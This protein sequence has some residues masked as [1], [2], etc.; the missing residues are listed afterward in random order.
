MSSKIEGAIIA[1]VAALCSLNCKSDGNTKQTGTP[2]VATA[3]PAAS[4]LTLPRAPTPPKNLPPRAVPTSWPVASGPAMAILAGK[5]VG[6]IR[7]GATVATIERLMAAPCEVR[8][9][10]ACRYYARG[11]EF[12]LKGGVVKEMHI[13]RPGRPA[14]KGFSYGIFN[15]STPEGV[16]TLVLERAV[17]E[18]I[19]A[20]PKKEAVAD[21]GAN[22][23]VDSWQ[24]PGM[25]VDFDR[26]GN[27]VV[28]GEIVL[29][30]G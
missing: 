19:G 4:M 30:K 12:L 23:T 13:S 1:V 3:R 11:I 22:G 17:P 6:P 18:L 9:A 10:D 25:R 20:P 5:G 24:Y 2:P 21:G 28:V 27:K 8:D 26:T 16:T 7:F 15:G 14:P 29:T